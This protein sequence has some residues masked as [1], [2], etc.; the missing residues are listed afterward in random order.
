[1]KS[2]AYLPPRE[3]V[4]RDPGQ[5]TADLGSHLHV[6]WRNR[7]LLLVCAVIGGAVALGIG[8]AAPRVYLAEAA[9]S[10]ARPKIGD[11][12]PAG[13]LM[14]TANY[15]PLIENRAIADKVIKENGLDKPPHAVSPSRFFG[16]V[17]TVEEVRASSVLMLRGQL[18]DPE[19]IARVVNR[20]AELGVETARRVSQQEALQARN[21]IKLQL[22]EART[23]LNDVTRTLENT[24]VASQV[25]M[26]KSDVKSALDQRGD[27]LK[28]QIMIEAERSK[29]ARAEKEL[30]SRNPLHTVRRSIDSDAGMME[31]ARTPDGKPRDLLSLQVK[32]EEVNATYEELDRELALSRTKLAAM[33]RQRAE[34]VSKKLAGPQ[35]AQLNQL[36]AKESAVDRLELER[37]LAKKVYQDVATSYETARLQVAG[38]NSALQMISMAI[39]ADRPESRKLGR[40]L[41]IGITSGLLLAALVVLVMNAFR[42]EVRV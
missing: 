27:L 37:D 38:R 25:E 40:H 4:P 41:L 33:E 21:D 29:V 9:L 14:S 6:L 39:P 1:M 19:L 17:V 31:A 23:R 5:E 8:L 16:Q 28:L 7:I 26:A 11:G 10:I 15:R 36:Y 18:D 22:D 34:L 42:S 24:R 30:S 12:L 35:L 3:I 2:T 20:V 13:E 32:N